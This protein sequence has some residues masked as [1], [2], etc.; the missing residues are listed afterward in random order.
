MKLTVGGRTSEALEDLVRERLDAALG[1][2][3]K[4]I[5]HVLVHFSDENGPRGGETDKLCRIEV[6]LRGSMRVLI[7]QRGD[8]F[9]VIANEAAERAKQ[10]VG[11]RIDRKREKVA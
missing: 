7:D 3:E 8:D 5:D 6:V 2:H 10:V 1:Q 11:R 4:W 9:Y